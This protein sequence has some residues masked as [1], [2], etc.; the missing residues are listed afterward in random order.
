MGTEGTIF[1]G[2]DKFRVVTHC[3]DRDEYEE[4]VL[5]E[6]LAY[7]IYALLTEISFRVRLARI[8]YGDCTS[9]DQMGQFPPRTDGHISNG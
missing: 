7:R 4:N 6:Y 9:S 5:E 2:Q 1:E 3:R 8:T